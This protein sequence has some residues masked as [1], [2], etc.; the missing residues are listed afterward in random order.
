MTTWILLRGLTR[1][2]AHWGAFP[3]QLRDVLG[4]H[5]A[6]VPVDLPGNGVLHRM[7]SPVRV[8]E[9]LHVVRDQVAGAG[10]APPYELLAMSLGAMVAAEWMAQAPHE[11]AGCALINT[12]LKPFSLVH[13][14][15]RPH[16]YPKLLRLA[17]VWSEPAVAEALI[18]RL[19]SSHAEPSRV[20]L[21]RWASIR[22]QRPV[23][24]ANA[25]RQLLAAARYSWSGEPPVTPVLLL[26][27]LGDRLVHPDCSTAIQQAWRCTQVAHG[28]A[29]HDL[30]LDA[31]DWVISQIVT[32]ARQRACMSAISGAGVT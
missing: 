4:P 5:A 15:L 1:E 20:T 26:N 23:S 29:G 11:L 13:H 25:L 21:D 22:E 30:P 7:R 3:R 19:T 12:S 16:N 28:R 24:R 9:M 8:Q 2:S 14:R 10:H 6:V 32:W 17:K 18:Y 27:S 31:P